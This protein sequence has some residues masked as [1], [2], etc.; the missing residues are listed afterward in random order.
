MER[1]GRR[2]RGDLKDQWGITVLKGKLEQRDQRVSLGYKGNNGELG[3][4]GE[5][6]SGGKRGKKGDMGPPRSSG[7]ERRYWADWTKGGSG[8]KG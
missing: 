6:G 5:K 1:V 3:I 2:E 8:R 4:Q 7:R